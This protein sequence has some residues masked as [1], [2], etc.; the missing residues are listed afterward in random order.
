MTNWINKNHYVLF[1]I[2][3]YI[4]ILILFLIKCGVFNF[5]RI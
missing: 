5:I 4:K 1:D 2:N 3:L